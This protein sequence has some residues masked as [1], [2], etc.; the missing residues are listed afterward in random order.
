MEFR[1]SR[2]LET[3]PETSVPAAL[4]YIR[5]DG[6]RKTDCSL[7]VDEARGGCSPGEAGHVSFV[8]M[9]PRPVIRPPLW[10]LPASS[11][12]GKARKTLIFPLGGYQALVLRPVSNSFAGLE[13]ARVRCSSWRGFCWCWRACLPPAAVLGIGKMSGFG[14][15]AGWWQTETSLPAA[16]AGT[17]S[18]YNL[19]A[20]ILETRCLMHTITH[21]HQMLCS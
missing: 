2:L 15:L 11:L 6:S 7:T 3:V 19:L 8:S 9:R 1:M 12:R 20:E 10:A 21:W 17:M 16:V 4:R 14:A 5:G 18:F 13:E